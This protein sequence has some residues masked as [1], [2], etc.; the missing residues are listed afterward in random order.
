MAQANTA[1]KAN[2]ATPEPMPAA[3]GSFCWNE[4]VTHDPERAKKFYAQTLG[5][6][7]EPWPLPE[8]TYWIAKMGER[9]VG[10]IFP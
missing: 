2:A 4:L 7:F 8:G 6:S 9:R 5:W 1:R 10:G 3:H